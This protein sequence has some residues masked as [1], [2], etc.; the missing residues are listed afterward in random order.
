MCQKIFSWYFLWWKHVIFVQEVIKEVLLN[1]YP[2]AFV[3]TTLYLHSWHGWSKL[4]FL[5][6]KTSLKSFIH[7][8]FV[9]FKP[10]FHLSLWFF[11]FFLIVFLYL[12][13]FLSDSFKLV[14]L[15]FLYQKKIKTNPDKQMLF[16]WKK[17]KYKKKN[18][19]EW[20]HRPPWGVDIFV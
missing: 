20:M 12:I 5:I 11:Y 3:L 13:L 19:L 7:V 6:L 16:K 17:K 15:C 14:L 1:F 4:I 18:N 10:S 9:R 8:I 2:F